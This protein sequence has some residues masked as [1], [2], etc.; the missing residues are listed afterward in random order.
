[1]VTCYADNKAMNKNEESIYQS[2]LLRLWRDSANSPWRASL[3]STATEQI[4]QFGDIGQM[5][6]FLMARLG[7]EQEG[8]EIDDTLPHKTDSDVAE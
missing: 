3:Q 1:M 7:G 2:Y 6:G 4:Y 5:R 8:L